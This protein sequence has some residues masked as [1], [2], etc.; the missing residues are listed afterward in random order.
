MVA[1]PHHLGPDPVQLG[2][3][4]PEHVEERSTVRHV[5][6]AAL[7]LG[8]PSQLVP[9]R[10]SEPLSQETAL[11]EEHEVAEE[12]GPVAARDMGAEP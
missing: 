3:V 7:G 6:S 12:S 1:A 4:D 5:G 11:G 2:E 10:P 8:S 9:D